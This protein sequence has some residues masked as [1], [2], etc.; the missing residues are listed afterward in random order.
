[1]RK[2]MGFLLLFVLG[3]FT[4]AYMLKTY[5]SNGL[6]GGFYAPAEVSESS[7]RA[8]LASLETPVTQGAPPTSFETMLR[9]AAQRISPAV[10]NVDT[11]GEVFTF[12][13]EARRVGGKGSGVIISRDGFVVTN[14]HVVRIGR[15]IAP[16]ITVTLADGRRFRARVI[17]TDAFNDIAL[18]KIEGRNLPVAPLGDSDQLHVGDWVIAVGN[19]FGLENTV[20]AGIVSALNRNLAGAGDV[21]GGLIQTDAAINAGN[22]G[23][24][25]ANSRG[26]LVG[27][28]TA[29]YSPVGANVGIGFAIPINRVRQVVREIL[30][31]GSIG[32]AWIGIACRDISDPAIRRFLQEQFPELR[33]PAQGML[34]LGVER[35]S[36]A[37]QA[38]L[39]P[40]DVLTTMNGRSLTSIEQ[41]LQM[42]RRVRLKEKIRFTVWREGRTWIV[43]VTP[44]ER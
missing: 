42:L 39:R 33:F 3:F 26:Q 13:G 27:I 25:L 28:N 37:E 12:W 43:E 1:M 41:F 5:F 32:S 35:N 34:I 7:K 38:G 19:P 4:G 10:V 24:A 6:M 30:E 44:V 17:G 14:N 18:L 20:T 2:V 36:P 21:P 15:E 8:L 16:E 9:T 29:I 22:S 11:T 23:G 31:Y 40:G